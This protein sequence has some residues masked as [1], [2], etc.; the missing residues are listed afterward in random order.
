MQ[1]VFNSTPSVYLAKVGLLPILKGLLLERSTTSGVK[2][3]VVDM[4]K[5]KAAKDAL[6]IEDAIQEKT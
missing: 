1:L 6:V 5:E 4:G 3:E 2:K